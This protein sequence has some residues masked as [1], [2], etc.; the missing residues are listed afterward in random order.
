MP[1]Y[2]YEARDS[3]GNLTTGF[4]AAKDEAELRA[5][6]RTKQLYLVK[7]RS[8]EA[9]AGS[10]SSGLLRKR[11]VSLSDLV[12]MSRQLATLVAAGLSI[13]E[14]IYGTAEQCENQLLAETLHQVRVDIIAGSTLSEAMGRHPKIFNE[15]YIALVQAG[16]AGGVLEETLE[17]AAVQ[18]DKEAELRDKVKSAAVYPI[19]VIIA[20]VAVTLFMLIVVVPVFDKVYKNFNAQL[21][22]MTQLLVVASRIVVSLWWVVLLAVIAAAIGLKR[23]YQTSQGRR[24]IDQ[25][26]LKL[27]LLGKLNR[28]IAISRFVRTFSAMSRAGVPILRSL[29]ISANTSGNIILI[30]AIQRVTQ[31]V[32]EGSGISAPMENTGEFP[33]MVTRMIAAGEQSGDLDGMLAQIAKFYDRDIEYTVNKLTRLL[34]PLMTVVVGGLVLFILL[35]LYMP[36]FNL[37]NV[38]RK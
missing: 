26:K 37:G 32:K 28:K 25:I 4:G 15:S 13:N 19:L 33:S 22:V 6:L 8:Q 10:S 24:V 14:A 3:T 27:P 31:M 5:T 30:N 16:E 18:F 17:T 2:L 11:K 9:A 38:L 35:A 1:T 34:E 7:V 36:V 20:S 23:Y 12:V 21:P 29:T